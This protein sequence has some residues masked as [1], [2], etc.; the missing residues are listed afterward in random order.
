MSDFLRAEAY[1]QAFGVSL[2]E[3]FRR[4]LE[5]ERLRFDGALADL[6]SYGDPME[7]W[8]DGQDL[9]SFV[10]DDWPDWGDDGCPYGHIS[11]TEIEFSGPLDGWVPLATI[12]EE[13]AQVL[14]CHAASADCAVAMWEHETGELVPV[15]PSLDTFLSALRPSP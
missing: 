7:L 8:F 13:Q 15:A 9:E 2:S 6:P 1:E 14:V 4:F 5:G 3:R 12:G 10:N 11:A